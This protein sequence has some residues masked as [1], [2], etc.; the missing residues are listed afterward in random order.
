MRFRAGQKAWIDIEV[1]AISECKN[2]SV[3]LYMINSKGMQI[4]DTS[5]DRLGLKAPTLAA[6]DTYNCT[7]EL[8]LNLAEGTFH[9]AVVL[10]RYDIQT[11]YD[12]WEPAATIYV[13]AESGVLGIVHC[14][15]K[16]VREEIR[17]PAEA[18]P[19]RSG[20]AVGY[21]EVNTIDQRHKSETRLNCALQP[22]ELC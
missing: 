18:D 1:D 20:T 2:F 16:V 3:T 12:Q 10:Y 14:F 6:G 11:V 19:S 21:T 13:G 7:F 5:T 9:P 17:P 4:F 15:P 22:G 8:N